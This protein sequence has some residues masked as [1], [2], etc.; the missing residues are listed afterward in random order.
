[1]KIKCFFKHKSHKLF[2]I[3]TGKEFPLLQGTVVLITSGKR[4][5]LV[6]TGYSSNEEILVKNLSSLGV[7]PFDIT[8]LVLTHYHLDHIG[9][10]RLFKKAKVYFGRE[11]YH[12]ILQILNKMENADDNDPFVFISRITG[13]V[14]EKKIRAILTVLKNNIE[15]LEY[16]AGHNRM[17]LIDDNLALDKVVKVEKTSGHSDGHISVFCNF[18][19]G[20]SICIAGD[21]LPTFSMADCNTPFPKGII[22]HNDSLFLKSR[23]RIKRSTIVI[24][25][26][27]EP[28]Y[29]HER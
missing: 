29:T 8:D 14:E 27:D 19:S 26:H 15:V 23:E 6:D 28:F 9:N 13:I 11:D 18:D 25:G 20:E 17:I 10:T 4:R 16:L 21:A 24:P 3:I 5:I 1:M 7:M 2:R 22:N 12:M